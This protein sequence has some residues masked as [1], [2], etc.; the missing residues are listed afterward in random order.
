EMRGGVAAAKRLETTVQP[1]VIARVL[2]MAGWVPYWRRDFEK[3]RSTFEEALRIT[4]ANPEEDRWA[5]A[6]ALVSLASSISPVGSEDDVLP[7]VQEALDLGRKMEDP[8]TIAGAQE[9]GG[10]SRER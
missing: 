6:R 9:R 10:N 3:S 8:F 1:W 4:R 7:L 2:L 5:E